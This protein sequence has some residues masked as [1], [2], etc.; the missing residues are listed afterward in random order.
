MYIDFDAKRLFGGTQRDVVN[1]KKIQYTKP[2]EC[3]K[4]LSSV[5]KYCKIHKLSARIQPMDENR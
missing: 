2:D 5:K 1:A 3:H 4:Y